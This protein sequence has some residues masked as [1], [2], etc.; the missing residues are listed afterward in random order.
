MNNYRKKVY[1]SSQVLQRGVKN[2]RKRRGQFHLNSYNSWTELDIFTKLRKHVY[3]ID[4]GQIKTFTQ[5]RHWWRYKIGKTV[6]H[7]NRWS[8]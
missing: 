2:V 8:E 7:N 3:D 4:F 6:T 5:I 1:I